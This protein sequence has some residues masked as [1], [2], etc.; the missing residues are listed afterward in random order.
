ME[1][2]EILFFARTTPF[3][4][5]GGMEIASWNLAKEFAKNGFSVSFITTKIEGREEIFFE[6]NIKIVALKKTKSRKYT[7]SW[8]RESKNYF[9]SLKGDIYGIISVSAG[10]YG[11]IEENLTAPTIFQ[12]HGTA[13]NEIKSKL[14][15]KNIK[16]LISF[17]INIISLFKDLLYYPKFSYIVASGDFIYQQLKSFPYKNLNPILINNGID[18]NLFKPIKNRDLKR[19]LGFKRDDYLIIS[20]S[21][22]HKQ[23]GLDL[24]LKAF[25]KLYQKDKNSKYLI[26]GEGR[27]KKKLK[28]LVKKLKIEEVVY[29]LGVKEREEIIK[30]LNISN[31]FLFTTLHNEGM[32]LNV[33]EALACGLPVILSKHLNGRFKNS[34]ELYFVNQYKSDEV[35]E[36]LLN[37]KKFNYSLLDEDLTL[38]RVFK[39]YSE[40]LKK[41][42]AK[43]LEPRA[44]NL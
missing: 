23:K 31:A 20:I 44:K 37:R 6:D 13:F 29:F 21:R 18:T 34:K 1:R 35:V 28:E 10:A 8:W 19:E 30:Y 11:I 33:M 12:A 14:K 5:I 41:R 26:I 40:L 15:S 24:S 7:K 36:A 17:P 25:A 38:N 3:H 42:R 4:N 16:N 43:G 22:L 39:A 9:L 27:E 2:R 32:P